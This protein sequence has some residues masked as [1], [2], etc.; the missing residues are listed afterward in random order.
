MPGSAV[1]SPRRA[2]A[3][4]NSTER[5]PGRPTLA[6]ARELRNQTRPCE[7]DRSAQTLAV[8][9]EL[10]ALLEEARRCLLVAALGLFQ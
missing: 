4:H 10:G 9:S 3:W 1:R 5:A 8:A 7:E 6:D 2:R